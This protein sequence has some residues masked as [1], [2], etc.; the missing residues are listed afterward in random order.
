MDYLA[1]ELFSYSGHAPSTIGIGGTNKVLPF[2]LRVLTACL[3]PLVSPTW[4]HPVCIGVEE[5]NKVCSV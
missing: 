4:L 5:H 2:L 1:I 3:N